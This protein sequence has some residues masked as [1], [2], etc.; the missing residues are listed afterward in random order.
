MT[1]TR[2]KTKANSIVT[3]NR[4]RRDSSPTNTIM[5]NDDTDSDIQI[6]N[7]TE[8]DSIVKNSLMSAWKDE[9]ELRS[10]FSWNDTEEDSN[11]LPRT[12]VRSIIPKKSM[13]T[14]RI[15][16]KNSI[17][18]GTPVTERSIQRSNQSQRFK[19]STI[20]KKTSQ[21]YHWSGTF[22]IKSSPKETHCHTYYSPRKDK[23]H[24]I[25]SQLTNYN[26][27]CEDF[28]KK[29]PATKRDTFHPNKFDPQTVDD[30]W[31]EIDSSD[32]QPCI[33]ICTDNFERC[34]NFK[35]Y[36]TDQ[37]NG[38]VP[39]ALSD[40]NI[41][42]RRKMNAGDKNKNTRDVNS[43]TNNSIILYSQLKHDI[44]VNKE[45]DNLCNDKEFINPLINIKSNSRK[46]INDTKEK[47]V[48]QL[49]CYKIWY[50]L[51]SFLKNVILFLLLPTAYII[52]FVYV[53]EKENK[54]QGNI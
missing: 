41:N 30:S 34:N 22:R 9:T 10:D 3:L 6:L 51:L 24:D 36:D 29:K 52:F 33:D 12:P 49:D 35:D 43:R 16:R 54:K 45:D 15:A 31:K 53:Q 38:A 46:M 42:L 44:N 20:G 5:I 25:K 48:V 13:T 17:N 11:V 7:T 18:K 23:L 40:I 28:A 27:Y 26:Y 50:S 2:S 47:S 32:C 21:K 4:H 37:D 19:G 14:G 39:A 1:D 8:I